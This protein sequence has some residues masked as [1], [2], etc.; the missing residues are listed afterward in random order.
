M[1]SLWLALG[2][3][4]AALG[5]AA[6][7]AAASAENQLSAEVASLHGA[8]TG[9][10]GALTVRLAE[11]LRAYEG[12]N[13][14]RAHFY[15]QERA[16]ERLGPREKIFLK[17]E[18]PFTIYLG[19][20]NTHKK[21]LQVLYARD[22]HDGKLAIHKPGLFLGLAPVVFLSQDS[23]W[24]REGSASY[25]IEDAGIGTFLFDLTRAVV[26]AARQRQLRVLPA[27][28]PDG[29]NFDIRFEGFRED[30]P[31]YFAYRVRV[32]FDESS[33]LPTRM[34]LFD[35][36]NR[37]T[38]IYSYEDLRLDVGRSDEEFRRQIDRHLYRVYE[39]T[40]ERA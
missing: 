11:G 23:P 20:L 3:L 6:A 7:S 33:A 38:G 32:N 15:K 12:L 22:R 24:V 26:R 25:D 27:G 14:Y 40:E 18:K 1:R 28:D 35:R 19:W 29:R 4:A 5:C 17:F 34:I 8:L 2:V 30:D 39:D 9:P 37:P 31:D 36:R 10:A 21:G 16:E 13:D